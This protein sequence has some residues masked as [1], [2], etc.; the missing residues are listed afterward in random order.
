M[1]EKLLKKQLWDMIRLIN[2]N[3]ETAYKPI[4]EIHG[5]T[6]MQSR[7]LIGINECD[8]PTVGNI[9]KIIDVSSPN[10][11]NM[12]KKL[13]QEGFI[14]RMRGLID[15][16]VVILKLTEKGEQTLLQIN[17][18]LKNMFGPIIEK[19]PEE[20]F[21]TIISGMKLLNKLLSELEDAGNRY[22]KTKEL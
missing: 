9:S 4:V 18:D 7:V 16:R 22:G 1:K 17:N 10:A 8:E 15:E 12:C 5:L 6:T 14:H 19:I 11:S 21:E 20:E 3:F 13:E 2:T